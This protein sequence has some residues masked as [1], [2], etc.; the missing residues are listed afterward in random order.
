VND[1]APNRLSRLR[2]TGRVSP[3]GRKSF[4]VQYRVRGAK[5]S[6][7][8]ERQVVLGTLAF[9]TVAQ[10]RDRA[11]QYKSKASEGIDP[12]E[13]KKEAKK[14]EEVQRKC[15]HLLEIG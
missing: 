8:T 5:G 15:L 6:K 10:A 3:K 7:W 2:F 4:I 12:V 13:E 1:D 14:A 9:L 11:R